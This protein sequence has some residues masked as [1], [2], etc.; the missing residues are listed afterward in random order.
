MVEQ[1]PSLSPCCFALTS[2]SALRTKFCSLTIRRLRLRFV[3]EGPCRSCD[4]YCSA[5]AGCSPLPIDIGPLQ[6]QILTGPYPGRQG[7]C[8]QREP[9]RFLS[10]LKKPA[11]LF[12]A[13]SLHLFAL[14]AR[15]VHSCAGI[16][17]QHLPT[18][19]LAKSRLD[20]RVGVLYRA[21]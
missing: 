4:M 12:D 19:C 14:H 5:Y 11:A 3:S 17:S 2:A 10:N 15:K 21:R 6:C 1:S 18:D 20:N 13:Q 16:L 9:F 7:Q 8:Q